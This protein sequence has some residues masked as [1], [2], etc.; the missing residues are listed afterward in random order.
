AHF[1]FSVFLHSQVHVN[2]LL[3]FTQSSNQYTP[4][5]SSLPAG[6]P[7]IA[8]FWADVDTRLEG[9]VYYRESTDSQL[10][11]RATT[12]VRSCFNYRGFTA[13][14]L[15]VATWSRVTYY[16]SQSNKVNTFQV[17][18]VTDRSKTFVLFNY[19]KI[20]WTTGTASGGVNGLGGIPA[21]GGVYSGDHTCF[22]TIPG[23]LSPEIINIISTTNANLPGRWAI[24][25]DAHDPEFTIFAGNNTKKYHLYNKTFK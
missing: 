13:R 18:L 17:V 15:F 1:T 7:F 2:G 3:S 12:D 8:P 10:L 24:K 5:L 22:Y 6:Y 19:G 21:V 25:V 20:Q 4:S 23:S 9:D 11:A 14:W 16:G